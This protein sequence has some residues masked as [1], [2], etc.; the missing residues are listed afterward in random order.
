[1]LVLCPFVQESRYLHV[2]RLME[3]ISRQY[4]KDVDEL[5]LHGEVNNSTL[6]AEG[7]FDSTFKE[8]YLREVPKGNLPQRVKVIHTKGK[9]E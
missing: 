9:F 1:M 8:N 4:N 3:H 6:I 2:Q 5:F 7:R